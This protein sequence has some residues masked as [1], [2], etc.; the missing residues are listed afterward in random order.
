MI[1]EPSD[2]KASSR[3]EHPQEACFLFGSLVSH[4]KACVWQQMGHLNVSLN[5]FGR[6]LE[7]LGHG[8]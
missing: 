5:P 2:V 4:W 3:V 8:R 7:T 6:G 1:A